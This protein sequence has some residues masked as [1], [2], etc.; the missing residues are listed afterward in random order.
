MPLFFAQEFVQGLSV[1][2]RGSV[3]EKLQWTFQLYDINGDG[4]ITRDE[5]TDIVTAIY[6]LMGR[7]PDSTGPEV[8]K[9]KDKV[10]TIFQVSRA[11]KLIYIYS[12]LCIHANIILKKKR[13]TI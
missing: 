9:I 13:E 6:E 1:L 2:S 8:E 12:T 10:D 3:E 5:M 7:H 4:Y 11:H